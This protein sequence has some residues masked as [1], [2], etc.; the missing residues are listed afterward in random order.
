[1]LPINESANHVCLVHNVSDA[2]TFGLKD[3]LVKIFSCDLP[4]HRADGVVAEWPSIEA[5]PCDAYLSV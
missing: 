4:P 2:A 1:M 5:V 3:G